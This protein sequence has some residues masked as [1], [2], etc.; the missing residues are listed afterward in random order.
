MS[1]W[2]HSV[3]LLL[4][5]LSLAL[6]LLLDI[7]LLDLSSLGVLAAVALKSF[8]QAGPRFAWSAERMEGAM[9]VGGVIFI[10]D[11]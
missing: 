5:L 9:M 11:L 1:T 2:N 10:V 7:V 4:L 8:A 3:L 6:L